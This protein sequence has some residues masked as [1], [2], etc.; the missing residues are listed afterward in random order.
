MP[1]S[2]PAPSAPPPPKAAASVG[3]VFN[4]PM[5]QSWRLWLYYMLA[6]R[7]AVDGIPHLYIDYNTLMK[8]PRAEGI[9]LQNFIGADAPADLPEKISGIIRPALRHSEYE[10]EQIEAKAGPDVAALYLECL[11]RPP[12]VQGQRLFSTLGDY[13]DGAKLFDFSRADVTPTFQLST[14]FGDY[15]TPEA[16]QRLAVQRLIPY[17]PDHRFDETYELKAPGARRLFF[18]PCARSLAR[19]CI[20]LV[21]IDGIPV[22]T[23]VNDTSASWSIDGWDVFHPREDAVYGLKGD[24]GKASKIRIR[25]RLETVVAGTPAVEQEWVRKA[26]SAMIAETMA[27]KARF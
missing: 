19:C 21:E 12:V 6:V 11:G 15:G 14:L 20:E 16:S 3:R 27:P 24:P 9:R 25:G 13:V 22:P 23:P 18:Q 7:A 1:P 5:E 17:V 10:I 4:L 2:A 26:L 8:D